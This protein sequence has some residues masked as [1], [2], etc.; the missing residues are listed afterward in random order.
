MV[1]MRVEWTLRLD[2]GFADLQICIC[3]NRAYRV[4]T[5][6]RV[7]I[8]RRQAFSYLFACQN[9][10]LRVLCYIEVPYSQKLSCH[11]TIPK[12]VVR[13][14]LL[15]AVNKLTSPFLTLIPP[16]E[17]TFNTTPDPCCMKCGIITAVL[18]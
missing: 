7:T 15:N 1:N 8:L 5:D 17:L 16:T 3:K 11:H 18:R 9:T 2:R 10:Q 6:T 13:R 4:D 14:V 12:P